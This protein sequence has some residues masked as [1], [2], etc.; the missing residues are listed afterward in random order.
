MDL[1]NVAMR[2]AAGLGG[3]KLPGE[4]HPEGSYICSEYAHECFKRIGLE[5]AYDQE[6]FIAPA[7]FANDPQVEAVFAISPDAPV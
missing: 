3:M 2:I 5:I 4:L 7:D 1:A 6:G